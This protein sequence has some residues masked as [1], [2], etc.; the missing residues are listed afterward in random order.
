VSLKSLTFAPILN[1][2]DADLIA[3]FFVP[4]LANAMHY[5]RGVG[6][7]SAGWLRI[8]A[9]GMVPFAVHG[10]RARW[11]TSPVLGAEDW[12]ALQTGE[13][14]RQDTLLHQ[15]VACTIEEIAQILVSSR[16]MA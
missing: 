4:A 2:S 5:D 8:T 3:D 12:Q 15:K 1:T 16:T 6:F 9:N 11:V 7:F 10:G 13:A 14:A